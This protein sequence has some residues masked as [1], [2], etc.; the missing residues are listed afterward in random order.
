MALSLLLLRVEWGE[1]IREIARLGKLPAPH[2]VKKV[3]VVLGGADL[4]DQEFRRFE[5]VHRVEEFPQHPHFLQ[6]LL[7]DQELFAAGGRAVARGP[8]L[9]G[10]PSQSSPRTEFPCAPS[11]FTSL[12]PSARA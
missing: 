12:Y 8:P 9:N 1:I 10:V 2:G 3:P 7:L 4:V 5:V 11:F 6:D